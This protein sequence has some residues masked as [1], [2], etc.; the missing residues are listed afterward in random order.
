MPADLTR[1][2]AAAKRMASLIGS[3]LQLSRLGRTDMKREQ[4]DAGAMAEEVAS[5]APR[6]PSLTATWRFRWFRM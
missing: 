1:I 4:L 3:I 6:A 5:D 2:Q